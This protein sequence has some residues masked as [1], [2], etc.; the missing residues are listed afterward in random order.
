MVVCNLTACLSEVSA[1]PRLPAVDR[2]AENHAEVPRGKR[3][4][5]GLS[6]GVFYATGIKIRGIERAVDGRISSREARRSRP[7]SRS[8]S[9]KMHFFRLLARFATKR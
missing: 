9:W 4:L 2:N 5:E 3:F 7:A 8:Q 6:I 1:K